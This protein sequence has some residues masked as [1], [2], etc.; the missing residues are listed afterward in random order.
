[1]TPTTFFAAARALPLASFGDL[2]GDGAAL[3]IAPHPDDE[4]LGCGALIAEAVEA[5][6][7]VRVIVVSDGT[8]SHPNSKAY[9]RERLRALRESEAREAITALGLAPENL[10]FLRLPDRYVPATGEAAEWATDEIVSTARA[11]RASAL[12]VTWR[13][14]P[15]CDH[16]AT[17]AL[18]REAQIQLKG[19]RLFE[20]AIWGEHTTLDTDPQASPRGFRLDS[21]RQRAR[22]RAAIAR[23][24][25]QVSRLID[26]DPDGFLLDP[27]MIAAFVARDEIF[28]EMGP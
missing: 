26:D 12:F 28:L 25:S 18:A 3:V 24:R 22:K 4:S 13:L 11:I 2:L 21:R 20:Y 7:S 15:H 9:P 5:R 19:V 1:M 8:G 27:E 14:D 6:R 16:R 23:Y 10:S 17:Y